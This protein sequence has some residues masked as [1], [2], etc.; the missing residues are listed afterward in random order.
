[1]KMLVKTKVIKRNGE[2][3][4]FD[5]GKIENAIRAANEE[6]DNIYKLN[7]FQVRAIADDIAGQV[8]KSTH[9]IHVEDIQDMVE[10]GSMCATVINVNWQESPIQQITG[11]LH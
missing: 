10:T 8:K 4:G 6:V 5:L 1:M 11:S 3:V 7:E 9:A 2:E